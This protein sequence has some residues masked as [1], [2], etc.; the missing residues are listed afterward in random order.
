VT[1]IDV[2]GQENEGTNNQSQIALIGLGRWGSQLLSLLS[3]NF[4]YIIHAVARS[5]Y[6]EWHGRE[7]TFAGVIVHNARNYSVEI[8][9][10]HSIQTVIVATEFSAHYQQVKDALLYGKNVFVEK[11]I[12]S[13]AHQ[14]AELVAIAKERKLKLVVGYRFMY[15]P[16][17][18]HLREV[19]NAGDLGIVLE[20]KLNMLNPVMGRV[21]DR[22][23][24]AIED[25]VSHMISILLLLFGEK[26]V[27]S[28]AVSVQKR[29]EKAII[30]FDYE[31]VKVSI[32]VDRDYEG[33]HY[34]RT[35]VAR[36]T[37]SIARVD[38]FN[39]FIE[40]GSSESKQAYR[41]ADIGNK[42]AVLLEF[43]AFFDALRTGRALVND[44]DAT[45][46]VSELVGEINRMAKS[47]EQ[48]MNGF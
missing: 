25:L 23:S 8:L 35:I 27:S 11:P 4:S 19:I 45:L 33:E 22:S 7:N 37:K 3:S 14:A 29:G 41:I 6:R 48:K 44:A 13:T 31:K 12:A 20:V 39:N 10:N 21:L 26:Y 34:K 40:M 28:L 32:S 42:N 15:D 30:S 2:K 16:N 5:N 38:Y 36:G 47:Q 18:N 1:I 43:I 24:N 46:F 9:E 17:I